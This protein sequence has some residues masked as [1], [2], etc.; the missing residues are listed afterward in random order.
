M[1]PQRQQ[2]KI[3]TVG[4]W[5][6]SRLWVNC[7]VNKRDILQ[8][9][10]ILSDVF[11]LKWYCFRLF[12]SFN[13]S[14]AGLQCC[15]SFK[16]TAEGFSYTC[17]FSFRVFPLW[18]ITQYWAVYVQQVGP[19]WLFI[20]YIT[21]CICLSQTPNLSFQPSSSFLRSK[22]WLQILGMKTCSQPETIRFWV[23][24]RAWQ[25][26]NLFQIK[27]LVKGRVRTRSEFV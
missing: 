18:V 6:N 9:K 21:V 13:W 16:C 5:L 17:P 7:D 12:L 10:T 26:N 8:G 2:T 19:C 22:I 25:L 23:C 4:F 24:L 27:L 1:Q 15:V 11:H 20:L 14:M 3:T